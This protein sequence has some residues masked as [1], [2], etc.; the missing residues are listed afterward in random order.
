[1][2][3]VQRLLIAAVA[4]AGCGADIE[5]VP[6]DGPPGASIAFGPSVQNGAAIGHWST[7]PDDALA[8]SLI[9]DAGGDGRFDA[10][11]DGSMPCVRE[12]SRWRCEAASQR[13]IVRTVNLDFQE[14]IL[15]PGRRRLMAC[16]ARACAGVNSVMRGPM[17]VL[18]ECGGSLDDAALVDATSGER[19]ALR[20]FLEHRAEVAWHVDSRRRGDRSEFELSAE[21][22]QVIAAAQLWSGTTSSRA[23]SDLV[24]LAPSLGRVSGVRGSGGAIVRVDLD[25][26]VV[27]RCRAKADCEVWVSLG[28]RTIAARVDGLRVEQ[29]DDHFVPL[30]RSSGIAP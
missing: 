8:V 30:L 25:E 13:V 27:A 5:G 18:R 21:P 16:D 7:V 29:L 19:I 22:M 26:G 6:V 11:V 10:D 4:T 17:E 9:D 20:G 2:A 1:M 24:P 28:V 3:V 14:L 12:T 23:G 15:T